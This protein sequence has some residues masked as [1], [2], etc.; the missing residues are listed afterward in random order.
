MPFLRLLP[1]RCSFSK[2]LADNM[3]K[4]FTEDNWPDPVIVD[5]SKKEKQSSEQK[6]PLPG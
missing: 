1:E 6:K 4:C 5:N 2:T 3:L